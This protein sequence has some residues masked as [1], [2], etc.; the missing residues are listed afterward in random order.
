MEFGKIV[1][2]NFANSIMHQIVNTNVHKYI[3]LP[4]DPNLDEFDRVYK[5]FEK[6]ITQLP[7]P[8]TMVTA[9]LRSQAEV[10]CGFEV[11]LPSN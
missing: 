4:D 8:I 9:L 6:D 1:V 7:S 5:I 11:S 3:G 10:S 2:G